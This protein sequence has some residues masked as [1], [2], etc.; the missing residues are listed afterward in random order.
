[1]PRKVVI[2][3]VAKSLLAFPFEKVDEILSAERVVAG[4]QL[5]VDELPAGVEGR[6]F[7]ATRGRWIQLQDLIEGREGGGFEQILILID[8]DR[9]A[10]YVVDQ[11]I[12]LEMLDDPQPMP[13]ETDGYL[14]KKYSGIHIWK[15]KV[16]LELDLSGLV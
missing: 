7:V 11:V 15:D 6:H 4:D 1:M 3:R 2:A 12:G 13:P 5:P 16:V 10:A 9:R 14:G 8:S